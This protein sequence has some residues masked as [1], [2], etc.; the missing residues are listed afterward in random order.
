MQ[1]PQYPQQ[2][3]QQQ[4]QTL[5]LQQ[6]HQPPPLN[7]TNPS[8]P[9]VRS[10]LA[11][12]D[13]IEACLSC[14]VCRTFVRVPRLTPCMHIVCTAC[15]KTHYD[16]ET[17]HCPVCEVITSERAVFWPVE[18]MERLSEILEAHPSFRAAIR[19]ALSRLETGELDSINKAEAARGFSSANLQS[20]FPPPRSSLSMPVHHPHP[21]QPETAPQPMSTQMHLQP[22]HYDAVHPPASQHMHPGG[23]EYL[24][25][26]QQPQTGIGGQPLP[27][28]MSAQSSQLAAARQSLALVQAGGETTPLSS[29]MPPPYTEL[30]PQGPP[31]GMGPR[32]T[33]GVPPPGPSHPHL[34]SSPAPLQQLHPNL[35]QPHQQIP[36][37]QTHT[38]PQPSALSPPDYALAGHAPSANSQVPPLPLQP[39]GHFLESPGGPEGPMGFAPP[40]GQYV[41]P[42]GAPVGYAPPQSQY[43]QPG[44][45]QQEM[46]PPPNAAEPREFHVHAQYLAAGSQRLPAGGGGHDPNLTAAFPQDPPNGMPGPGPAGGPR[47]L[48]GPMQPSAE[49]TPSMRG[50][51]E[52]QGYPMQNSGPHGNPMPGPGPQGS[53]ILR[54]PL[55]PGVFPMHRHQ[56]PSPSLPPAHPLRATPFPNGPAQNL[57]GAPHLQG[58]LLTPPGTVADPRQQQQQGG[59]RYP[60]QQNGSGVGL[61][62]EAQ[63]GGS[64]EDRQKGGAKQQLQPKKGQKAFPVSA[65][66]PPPPP[67]PPPGGAA[68]AGSGTPSG[69]APASSPAAAVGRYPQNQQPPFASANSFAARAMRYV[70]V[71][72]AGG[73]KQGS[74]AA[75]TPPSSTTPTPAAGTAASGTTA[76]G[77]A[78]G[79]AMK[80]GPPGSN[81]FLC[82]LPEWATDTDILNMTK[83][84]VKVLGVRVMKHDSGASKSIAHLSL[85]SPREAFQAIRSLNGKVMTL[86][87]SDKR[88]AGRPPGF[89]QKI[90]IKADVRKTELA[91]MLC[92]LSPEEA[93]ELLMRTS[94]ISGGNQE[95]EL[96]EH[97]VSATA[98]QGTTPTPAP[99][100]PPP[101]LLGESPSDLATA[102][103]AVAEAA[104]ATSAHQQRAQQQ[105][106]KRTEGGAGE[107]GLN[108]V[109]GH[110]WQQPEIRP[111]EKK[112]GTDSWNLVAK[113]AAPPPGLPA[114]VNVNGDV[115]VKEVA[116][117]EGQTGIGR[118]KETQQLVA[119][120]AAQEEQGDEEEVWNEGSRNGKVDTNEAETHTTEEKEAMRENEKP[121][122]EQDQRNG[123][124]ELKEE[125][126]SPAA[127]QVAEVSLPAASPVF[128]EEEEGKEENPGKGKEVESKEAEVVPLGESQ[129]FPPVVAEERTKKTAEEEELPADKPATSADSLQPP[130]QSEE[131]G[132]KA[133]EGGEKKTAQGEEKKDD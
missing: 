14:P 44:V 101:G 102:A 70:A 64:V 72:K 89:F 4:G 115:G 46:L 107:T 80:K 29:D 126:Q 82:R 109:D 15:I 24:G 112:E 92:C 20:A 7:A 11:A 42:G 122:E 85:A 59:E 100:Q 74:S 83:K 53:P 93:R 69:S 8:V 97:S 2:L 60:M 94:Y 61:P 106:Q 63:A 18:Q 116:E 71:P 131:E 3:Q 113:P 48:E 108:G 99:T 128:V 73:S 76:G 56:G 19:T 31:P 81:I 75:T 28:L 111:S 54:P 119:M 38:M 26:Y 10:L 22:Q 77:V 23:G 114:N 52:P 125:S 117:K 127:P 66:Y 43:L 45:G 27:G 6:A 121:E 62:P 58:P 68:A 33:R 104:A 41:Q 120:G 49:L 88:A 57:S 132:E 87:P 37:Q 9:P 124:E 90:P 35:P 110:H 123:H 39:N 65:E 67:P 32:M 95:A 96:Q 55:D 86:D 5:P 47:P 51:P 79:G 36:P 84:Y 12:W 78:T 21:Q 17:F 30:G 25:Q 98:A 40:Q 130:R 13:E 1:Q 105:Q 91:D 133:E 50:M 129:D 34:L 118:A 16:G 103:A